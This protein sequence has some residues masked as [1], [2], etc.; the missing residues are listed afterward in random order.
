M[1]VSSSDNGKKGVKNPTIFQPGNDAAQK[2]G[3]AGAVRALAKGEPFSALA[4]EQ[5]QQVK[6][7]YTTGGEGA[8]LKRNATRLQTAADL[9]YQAVIG[10]ESAEAMTSYLK[11]WVWLTN[12]TVRAWEAVGRAKESDRDINAIDVINAIKAVQDEK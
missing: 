12:S 8:L 5:E 2:H 9:Y 3:G 4:A 11:V 1:A 10:A 6:S 7:E